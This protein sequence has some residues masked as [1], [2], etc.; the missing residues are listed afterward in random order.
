MDH[1]IATHLII[2]CDRGKNAE[3]V[4]RKAVKKIPYGVIGI[5]RNGR[6][7]AL[8]HGLVSHVDGS[9]GIQNHKPGRIDDP[10]IGG[11]VSVQGVKLF[12]HRV[13]GGF[14]VVQICGIGVGNQGGLPVK[15]LR[16][17][18]CELLSSHIADKGGYHYKAEETENKIGQQKFQ[19]EGF[20]HCLTSNL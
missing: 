10:Q 18:S 4:L 16:F 13:Q 1:H 19:V 5:F 7:K 15:G 20:S 6:I 11:K 8:D 9:V 2:G 3:L 17:L 12:F 14:I